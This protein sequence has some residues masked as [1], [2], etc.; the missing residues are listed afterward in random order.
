MLQFQIRQLGKACL[1][2]DSKTF[3]DQIPVAVQ[4]ASRESLLSCHYLVI[5][6]IA[7]ALQI[8]GLVIKIAPLM[9]CILACKQPPT[10]NV[11]A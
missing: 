8:V 7:T 10:Q 1:L 5:I 2:M 9:S 6:I 11:H 3:M 4:V